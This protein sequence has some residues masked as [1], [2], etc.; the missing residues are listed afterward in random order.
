MTDTTI[1]PRLRV[2]GTCHHFGSCLGHTWCGQELA[3]LP[4]HEE[5]VDGYG[6]MEWSLPRS[7]RR[8]VRDRCD[9]WYPYYEPPVVSG[10]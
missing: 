2:C 10:K 5:F 1:D 7:V 9:D 8:G 4:D 3:R 6:V